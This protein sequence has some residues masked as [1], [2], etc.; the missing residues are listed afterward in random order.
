MITACKQQFHGE[1]GE[2]LVKSG[3]RDFEALWSLPGEPVD[4]P[5][6]RHHGSSVVSRHRLR[7]DDGG[8]RI[9]YLKRQQDYFPRHALSKRRLLLCREYRRIRLFNAR[10]VNCLEVS[11]VA[12]RGRSAPVRGVLV[13]VALVDHVPLDQLLDQLGNRLPDVVVIAVASF[14]GNMHRCRLMHGNLYPKHIYVHRGLLSRSPAPDPIRVIDLEDACWMPWTRLARVRDLDKL[15]RYC[16]SFS[17]F[18]RLRFLLRYLG[19][20]RLSRGQRQLLHA[21]VRRG[22][23]RGPTGARIG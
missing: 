22:R 21:I 9:F 4:E 17:T 11:A 12:I 3:I 7:G 20:T 8:E 18:R 1:G 14:L 19:V 16:A 2:F 5:N 13:T 10:G 6:L 15:N 23:D